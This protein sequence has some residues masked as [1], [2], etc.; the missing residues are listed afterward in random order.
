MDDDFQKELSQIKDDIMLEKIELEILN[1]L[2][3]E[4]RPMRAKEISALLD[5]TYQ[6]VGKRTAKL[7]EQGLIEKTVDEQNI[8]T[9]IACKIYFV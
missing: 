4:N 2:K 3:G 9:D 6:L 5:V 7:K 8:I 1:I